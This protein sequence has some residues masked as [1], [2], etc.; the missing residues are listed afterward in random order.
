[1]SDFKLNIN[2]GN[3]LIQ[4]EGEGTLVQ[5]ILSELREKGLG[6]LAKINTTQSNNSNVY[7]EDNISGSDILVKDQDESPNVD[8]PSLRD[9][10]FKAL[11]KNEPEWVLIYAFY[12]SGYGTK[13]VTKVD[14]KNMYNVTNRMTTSRNSNF[15]NNLSSNVSSNYLSALNDEEFIIRDEGVKKVNEILLRG[16]SS[17]ESK[18]NQKKTIKAKTPQLIKDLD[19]KENSSR[20]GLKNFIDELAP[21][22]DIHTTTAIIY[23]LQQIYGYQNINID[24]I[25]TCWRELGVKLPTNLTGNLQHIC[26]S[27]YG[28]AHVENGIYTISTRGINLV[29][30]TLKEDNK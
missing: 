6:E 3:M 30:H 20:K 23:Y 4:L 26:G 11:P 29:E 28:F 8:Y 25:F 9:I 15:F 16:N 10:A 18:G 14:I 12:A 21:K 7:K 17:V 13:S 5:S 27:R 24:V 2:M 1:M 19:L 22:S